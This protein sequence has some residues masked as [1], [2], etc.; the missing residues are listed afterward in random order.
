[1]TVSFLSF[2]ASRIHPENVSLTM[3]PQGVLPNCRNSFQDK[4][5]G[6]KLLDVA[7]QK[8]KSSGCFDLRCSRLRR[9]S[10]AAQHDKSETFRKTG[11]LLPHLAFLDQQ[12][13]SRSSAPLTLTHQEKYLARVERLS[14]TKTETVFG[15][16]S[17][18][19]FLRS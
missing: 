4:L 16:K 8:E 5:H 15:D 3:L 14:Q 6:R 1:M 10:R 12:K 11:A 7:W 17:H 2:G 13:R 9:D 19:F 18:F